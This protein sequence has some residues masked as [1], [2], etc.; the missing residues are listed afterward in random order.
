MMN[1]RR[2]FVVWAGSFVAVAGAVIT[3]STLVPPGLNAQSGGA[4]ANAGP[5]AA[6]FAAPSIFS[7]TGSEVGLSGIFSTATADFN[8]DGIPDVVVAGFGGSHGKGNPP[9][10]I[11]VYLGKGDGTLSPPVYYLAGSF[12]I[13]VTTGRMRGKNAPD[14]LIVLNAGD[15]SVSVLL[16]NGNG[17]FQAPIKA[18]AFPNNS[19]T[20]VTAAD[21]NGDGK[22]DIAV[23]MF[24]GITPD[25]PT[26]LFTTIGV[27]L[28]KGDG[29]FGSPSFYQSA[30]NPYQVA[31]G[32]F[33]NSGKLDLLIRNP[34]GIWLSVG[35]GDGTFQPGAVIWEE[36]STLIFVTPPGPL[37][38][39]PASFA[40]G[41]FNGDGKL[42]LAVDIDGARM[43][44]LL[45]TGTGAFNPAPIPTYIFTAN[46]TGGGGG[47]IAAADLTGNGKLDLV[48]A[49]GYGAT[50]AIFYSNGDGTFQSPLIYPLPEYDDE[51]V[52][53]ADFNSD[54]KPDILVG[55][56]GGSDVNNYFT[57]LLNQ[58]PNRFGPPPKQFPVG[59]PADN[60][61]NAVAIALGDL[62]GK[63]RQD[64]VVSVWGNSAGPLIN[65]QF[66]SPPTVTPGGQVQNRDSISVLLGNNDG[67]FQGPKQYLVGT[68][69][70][71]IVLASLTGDGKQDAV[72]ANIIS[73]DVSVLKGNGDGTF[74]SAITIPLGKNPNALAVKDLNGDGKPDIAVT[75]LSD[76]T[77]SVLLNTS[78]ASGQLSFASPV[79][80]SVGQNPAGV[81][82]GDFNHDGKIDLAV[83][84][85]GDPFAITSSTTLS[86]LFGNGNGTFQPATTQV[87]WKTYGGDALVGGDFNGDGNLDL[88]VANFPRGEVMVLRGQ[89]NGTFVPAGTYTVGAGA[90]GIVVSD[91]NG[92]GRLDL[93]VNG[94][95]D[96][97]I[98][99]LAGNGDGTFVPVVDR[100]TDKTVPFGWPAFPYPAFIAGG[101]LT[102]DGKPDLV[103][104]NITNK[105]VT[106]LLNATPSVSPTPTPTPTPTV[107]P[108]ATPTP[109]VS[110]SS[111]PTPTPTSTPTAT[112]TPSPTPTATPPDV[113][114][115]NVSGRLLVQ[116]QDNVG[117]GG[118]IITGASQK[119]VIIRAIGPSMKV[120]GQP[121]PGRLLD[122]MLELHDG[123]GALIQTNDNWRSDQ[124]SAIQQSGL[125]P[126]DDHESA[127]IAILPR[128]NY[129]AIV[130]GAN[131]TTGVGLVE[132]YDLESDAG[133]LGNLSVRANVQT[134]DNV[135]I[136]GIIIGGSTP[137]RV[138]FRAL[139]P[140]IKS[141][142]TPVPGRLEDPALELHDGNGTLLMGNDN[143]KDAP[144]AAEIAATGLAPANDRES[145]ILLPLSAGNYTAILRGVNR[146]TGIALGEIYKLTN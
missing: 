40:V 30:N 115:R 78:T 27:C 84:N 5:P 15:N 139:G 39:G 95:N 137:K 124:E 79:S 136:D 69:P 100:A 9:N 134:D 58:G 7:V 34:D 105:T 18:V 65:G 8:G 20:C 53:L 45:G 16:G 29:T 61:I 44:V 140:S 37:F 138:L 48:V 117:I 13:Q 142:G 101:D 35:N 121:V 86:V 71:A 93:A 51:T 144:N 68:H 47:S 67:T 62:T 97:T 126:S 109:T 63:G 21:L 99:F 118:F 87:L 91:F 14:D 42:D 10:S 77:V 123:R 90:E 56:N 54:G 2:S 132:I 72:V 85:D 108:G 43:D 33:R 83:V 96:D 82:A 64:A 52:T 111:T 70:I 66:P 141:S 76:N 143:W 31:A 49:T 50:L 81:V 102:G 60:N 38:N 17:T 106:V 75:N 80:Y 19:V 119:R 32:D 145:A 89:S 131:S 88:A 113:Q 112:A 36:P 3:V 26:G 74:Q 130:K 107:T 129:T 73:N 146:T 41:D 98:A 22:P 127:I 11:A 25:S 4:N 28:G 116:T 122:P 59:S 12:P 104:T 128:G 114:L 23:T 92:D 1:Y 125:A 120:N 24:G 57:M 46:Q 94:I 135:L 55:T 6:R 110:P 133:E 103:A